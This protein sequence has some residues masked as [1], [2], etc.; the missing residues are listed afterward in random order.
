MERK[1]KKLSGRE[2]SKSVDWGE[3]KE[4]KGNISDFRAINYDGKERKCLTLTTEAGE[5]FTL[6]ESKGLRPLVEINEG[7]YVEIKNLGMRKTKSGYKMR[8]FDIS[9]DEGQL[10]LPI[11]F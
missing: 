10:E 1:M 11:P 8:A 6:W 4:L 3:V 7:V 5:S 2:F 9:A